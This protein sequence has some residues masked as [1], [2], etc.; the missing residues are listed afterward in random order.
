MNLGSG[1]S[2]LVLDAVVESGNPADSGRCLPM[3][4]RHSEIYGSM[5]EQV[6]FDGGHASKAN[7]AVAKALVSCHT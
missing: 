3:I 2:G 4:E 1:A 6:A 5:P 7:P